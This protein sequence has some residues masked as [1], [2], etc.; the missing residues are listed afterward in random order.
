MTIMSSQE[1]SISPILLE[2]EVSW[3]SQ[4]STVYSPVSN[5]KIDNEPDNEI[6]DE[7]NNEHLHTTEILKHDR[8][9]RRVIQ[10]TKPSAFSTP[11]QINSSR[12]NA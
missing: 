8:K 7:A 10:T 3:T 2:D 6:N 11:I 9:K 5:N 12:T 1:R 4:E